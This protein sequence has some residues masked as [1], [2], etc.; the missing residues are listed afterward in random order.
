MC[1]DFALLVRFAAS[2]KCYV[3]RF[4]AVRQVYD[5]ELA[6]HGPS[7]LTIERATVFVSDPAYWCLRGEPIE[8]LKEWF[9]PV[10]IT[11]NGQEYFINGD[12]VLTLNHSY[13]VY[14]KLLFKHYR[15]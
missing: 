10:R 7:G 13:R 8:Y 11:I 4:F 5:C 12:E 14:G 15:D 3:T 2:V 6:L 9:G 1:C